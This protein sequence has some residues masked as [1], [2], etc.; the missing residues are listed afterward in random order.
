MQLFW[1]LF[2]RFLR[3]SKLCYFFKIKTSYFLITFFPTSMSTT[4]WLNPIYSN[5]DIENIKKILR[6]GDTY[7]DIGA[8]IGHLALA[9]SNFVGDKGTVI[10]VEGN[11]KVAKFL[12]SL[13]IVTSM[14]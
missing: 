10:A 2:S 1:F 12:N 5:S 4:L 14:P 7:V 6:K 8:N 3:H 11:L 13:K 9:A